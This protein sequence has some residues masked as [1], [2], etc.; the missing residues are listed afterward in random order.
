MYR[1]INFINASSRSA[2]WVLLLALA[3]L[4]LTACGGEAKKSTIISNPCAGF[5]FCVDATNGLDTNT[6]TQ[7]APFKTITMAAAMATTAG[8]TVKVLPG[9]YD[10]PGNG[11]IFPIVINAG[12]SLIGDEAGK[13]NPGG[14]NEV[15]IADG[16]FTLNTGAVLAG[17][18]V[19]GTGQY[20]VHTTSGQN[21][22]RNNSM[23]PG[24][25]G[26]GV[27]ITDG[28]GG[29]VITGN[30]I[31]NTYMGIFQNPVAP[32]Q[33]S[34][35]ENN[36]LY[37]NQFAV[38]MDGVGLDLGG[39]ITGSVGGNVLSC[40]VFADYWTNVATT[41]NMANN[42][43]DHAPPLEATVYDGTTIGIYDLFNTVAGGVLNTTGAQLASVRGFT[44]CP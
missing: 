2:L 37:G 26:A 13:G 6:G 35:V 38:E 3:L 1:M 8:Q 39:G 32:A 42:Y 10:N 21:T 29:H 40:S 33:F 28:I 23:A 18:S 27:W 5:S 31:T 20:V 36:V 16:T 44:V 30:I 22:I 15:L 4:S 9:V 41:V 25:G 11:E 24:S 14:V 17:F 43:W 19:K 7:D 34:R 12:V